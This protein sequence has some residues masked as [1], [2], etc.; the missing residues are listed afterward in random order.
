MSLRTHREKT[1]PLLSHR[2]LDNLRLRLFNQTPRAAYNQL[3]IAALA[4]PAIFVMNVVVT[5]FNEPRFVKHP[6]DGPVEQ[7]GVIELADLA[8]EPEMDAGDR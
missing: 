8:I 1:L 4:V 7:D 5:S 6:L 2:H 3:D